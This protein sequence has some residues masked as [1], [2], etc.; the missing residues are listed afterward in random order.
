MYFCIFG[1]FLCFCSVYLMQTNVL[2]CF[3]FWLCNLFSEKCKGNKDEV[4]SDIDESQI[5]SELMN[6]DLEDLLLDSDSSRPSS[7]SSSRPTSSLAFSQEV[8][9]QI[10]LYIMCEIVYAHLLML[11]VHLH[12]FITCC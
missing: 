7:R 9:K 2:F 8:I 11:N 12:S 3:V 5:D 6:D 1:I 10:I 4:D